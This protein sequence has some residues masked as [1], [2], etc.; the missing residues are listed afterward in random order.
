MYQLFETKSNTLED[1][2][3]KGDKSFK[4]LS[5]FLACRYRMKLMEEGEKSEYVDP[6]QNLGP[7]KVDMYRAHFLQNRYRFPF[8][9]NLGKVKLVE[10]KV[11]TLKDI[12]K[13]EILTFY[14]ADVFFSGL[15]DGNMSMVL[16]DRLKEK[17]K[18]RTVSDQQFIYGMKYKYRMDDTHFITGH[19]SYTD[20]DG[21]LAHLIA[22]PCPE[23][24]DEESYSLENVNCELA[25]SKSNLFVAAIALQDIPKDTQLFRSYG[26]EYWNAIK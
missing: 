8:F 10:G 2:L 11:C 22:D 14:P 20:N 13:G 5:D 1:E 15:E 19:P 26:Y 16:S 4:T 7:Y 9:K 6:K 23:P 25:N 3:K 18:Q 17:F 12:K 24:H 21:M